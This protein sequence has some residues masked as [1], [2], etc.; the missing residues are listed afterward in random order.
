MINTNR[1]PTAVEKFLLH[2]HPSKIDER[3]IKFTKTFGL[4][5]INAL[6]FV[7]LVFTG[8]LFSIDP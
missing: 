1:K 8:I 5:G 6:L 2:I 7:I 3:A 4:G